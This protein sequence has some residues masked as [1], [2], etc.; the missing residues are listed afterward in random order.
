[1][2]TGGPTPPRAEQEL[3]EMQAALEEAQRE[4]ERQHRKKLHYQDKLETACQKQRVAEEAACE[5]QDYAHRVDVEKSA[6]IQ[7]LEEQLTAQCQAATDA[8]VRALD[9]E[10]TR[11]LLEE[12]EIDNV[13]KL[14]VLQASLSDA[15]ERVEELKTDAVDLLGQIEALQE[16]VKAQ[17]ELRAAETRKHEQELLIAVQGRAR[18]LLN[19]VDER[20][21]TIE[22]TKMCN[23][24]FHAMM[25]IIKEIGE[26][27][28]SLA[29][30]RQIASDM[31]KK[32]DCA[33][34]TH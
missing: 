34:G 17:K 14:Q 19:Y 9:A 5:A 22:L 20:K 13:D 30:A 3:N 15:E 18:A 1:M 32:C 21:K 7:R 33:P 11:R 31:S 16:Q 10:Q 28:R 6:E 25:A 29:E 2:P 27:K 8:E 4:C 23:S 24:T 26:G 12:R